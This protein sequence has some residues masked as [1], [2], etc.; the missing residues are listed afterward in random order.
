MLDTLRRIVQEVSS[1]P[2]LD[3]ALEMIVQRVKQAMAVEVCSVYLTDPIQK[4]HILMATE[5]LRPESVLMVRLAL[6]EGL[7]GLVAS[8]AEP[9]N[10]K[11]A[12]THPRYRY[13]P[14]SGEEEYHG[15]LGVPIIHHRNVLGV[16]VVQHHAA[17][18]F[19]EDSVTLLVTI[20]AQLAGAI[21]HAEASGEIATLKLLKRN[22]T[23]DYRPLV[24]I[25][26]APGV[27]IGTAVVM[28]P[29]ENLDAIPDRL[30]SDIDLEL[31]LFHD[32][33]EQVKIDIRNVSDRLAEVLPSEDKALFDAYLMML[34]GDSLVR[35]TEDRIRDGAWAP[36]ALR[37]TVREHVRVFTDMEDPYLRERAD[38]VRDLGGRLLRYLQEDPKQLPYLCDRAVLVGEEIT[39]TM[40]ADAPHGKLAGIIS[41]R[42]SRTSHASILARALGVPAVMGVEEL[43]VG[44]MDGSS[45]IADGY[46]GRVYVSPSETVRRE[47]ERVAR[48]EAQLSEE[49]NELR[50]LP[51]QTTDGVIIPL[52]ANSGL[53]ADITPIMN[54]GAE[55]IGLYRTEYPFM[56]RQHFPGEEGQ[57]KTYRR[58]LEQMAPCPVTMRTL[59]VGGDKALPYFPIQEDNPFLGWR[60]IRITLDHPEIFLVQ[61]RAMLRAN[62]GLSNLNILLPMISNVWELDEALALLRQV[63]EELLEEGE[64]VTMPPLGV[65]VEVPSAVYQAENLARRVDFLS[66]GTND[67]TQYLLA[68]DRNNARVADLYDALHPAVLRAMLQVVEGAAR[69]GKPV[70]ICGEMAGDP[71]AT[72][73]LIGMGLES[74]SLS[75]ASLQRVKWV[76][77]SFSQAQAR[78]ILQHVLSMENPR[79]IRRYLISV[80]DGAGL[81]ALVRPGM[82]SPV[83]VS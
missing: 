81:G 15:F 68:V 43:P 5:G 53:L 13:F 56:I 33:V 20:A 1:A 60:G 32:A 37:D 48:D 63:Y 77:R 80:L 35:T 73:L 11:D 25:P 2:N 12:P 78:D 21:A 50:D 4:E 45:V 7:I 18:E 51:C 17:E 75:V 59:D 14:E 31:R 49:L 38:D 44:R 19:G 24:G 72:P 57:R 55:G 52:F 47:Y 28:Y 39:A 3:A 29:M 83:M 41:A 64:Q 40:I 82:L 46:S 79:A 42:G 65:M 61:A 6:D 23:D 9:V 66:I 16:L 36:A 58:I 70:T 22:A 67:L 27:G 10:L 71:V 8:R 76:V 62:V 54:S 69:A 34:D 74:L 26:G 30:A